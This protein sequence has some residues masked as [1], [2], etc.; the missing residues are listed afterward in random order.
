MHWIELQCEGVVSNEMDSRANSCSIN[1]FEF[2]HLLNGRHPSPPPHPITD[3]L[4]G[5]SRQKEVSQGHT[6]EG[7]L[8]GWHYRATHCS[9]ESDFARILREGEGG[10]LLGKGFLPWRIEGWGEEGISDTWIWMEN[11]VTI[12]FKD[13]NCYTFLGN[14]GVWKQFLLNSLNRNRNGR[15]HVVTTRISL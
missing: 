7:G 9:S 6:G 5:N 14:L 3:I 4:A 15:Q 8:L 10:L 12:I 11:C 13:Q 1:R 2:A